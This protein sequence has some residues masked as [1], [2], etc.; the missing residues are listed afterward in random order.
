ME[1][2]SL[3]VDGSTLG[4]ASVQ[5]PSGHHSVAVRV[6]NSTTGRSAEIR[7]FGFW[8]STTIHPSNGMF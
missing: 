6:G 2:A 4:A 5:L 7:I 3:D 8:F 1:E